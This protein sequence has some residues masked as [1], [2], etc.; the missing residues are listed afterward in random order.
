MCHFMCF[1]KEEN[2][3]NIKHLTKLTAAKRRLTTF[4]CTLHLERF[5]ALSAI[6]AQ[7][8]Q[9]H[10]KAASESFSLMQAKYL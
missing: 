8:K 6:T 9:Q 5:T 2:M 10:S 7:A 3:L 1:Y 4:L